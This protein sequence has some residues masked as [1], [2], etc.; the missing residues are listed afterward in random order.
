MYEKAKILATKA[1]DGQ[2]RWDK[3]IPYI[4]HPLAIADRFADPFYKSVAV[5]HDIVEDTTI[6][7]EFLRTQFPNIIVDAI[8]AITHRDEETYDVYIMRVMKNPLARAVKIQDVKHNVSTLPE[9]N[10]TQT[11]LRRERC[12]LA[13]ILLENAERWGC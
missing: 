8:D 2:T 5:L 10:T 12:A 13:L 11:R 6:T 1:H 3:S 9:D 4:T 7:L